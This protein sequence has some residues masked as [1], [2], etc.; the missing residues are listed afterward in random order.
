MQGFGYRWGNGWVA[1]RR[2]LLDCRP[3]G[4]VRGGRRVVEITNTACN[5]QH[6]AFP[7]WHKKMPP[8]AIGGSQF[9]K[10]KVH[11]GWYT[12]DQRSLH[13]HAQL[14]RSRIDTGVKFT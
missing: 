13:P 4:K 11:P 14:P 12:L 8:S 2:V 9:E 7:P 3:R 10:E 6:G 1:C 5:C